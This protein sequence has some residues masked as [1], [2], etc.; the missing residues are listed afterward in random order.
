[1]EV[2]RMTT[3]ILDIPAELYE[4]LDAEARRL[5]KPAQLIA[6]ELLKEKLDRLH[7]KPVQTEH[8]Q[9]VSVLKQAGLLAEPG[10][11]M[12]HLAARPRATLEEAHR[13]FARS[14]G[15]P[16]SEIV[17]EQRGPKE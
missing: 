5:Q 7:A 10:P 2:T 17:L 16:L 14:E 12:V 4:Q 13:A 11:A 3:L 6:Q 9:L 15:K 1:M 8:E